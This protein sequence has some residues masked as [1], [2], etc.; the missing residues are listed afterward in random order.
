MST[1]RQEDDEFRGVAMA[2]TEDL[3]RA[4]DP[5]EA[6]ERFSRFLELINLRIRRV[7]GVCCMASIASYSVGLVVAR[8]GEPVPAGVLLTSAGLATAACVAWVWW[9]HRAA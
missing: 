1:E 5:L 8:Q 9:T 6:M 4:P 2:L 3:R 7:R